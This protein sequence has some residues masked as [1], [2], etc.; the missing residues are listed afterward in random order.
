MSNLAAAPAA[1][2]SVFGFGNF[3]S[4]QDRREGAGADAHIMPAGS[5]RALSYQLPALRRANLTVVASPLI[6]LKRNQ[7]AQL[8]GS[9][10][11]TH[12]Q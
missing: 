3:R 5:G 4:G 9:R 1:L 10:A 2:R 11:S 8:D 6:A 12:R 7:V